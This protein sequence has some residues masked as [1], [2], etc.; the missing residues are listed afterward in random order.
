[1]AEGETLLCKITNTEDQIT[2]V[3]AQL[4]IHISCAIDIQKMWTK[5]NI[6]V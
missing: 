1:M 4:R 6:L 3:A 5:T 2:V